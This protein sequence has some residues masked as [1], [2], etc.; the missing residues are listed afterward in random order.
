M[1]RL[2]VMMPTATYGL[3]QKVRPMDLLTSSGS[4]VT[5]AA[6]GKAVRIWAARRHL[7]GSTTVDLLCRWAP[8]DVVAKFGAPTATVTLS[9]SYKFSLRGNGAGGLES[10]R[11]GV[12]V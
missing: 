10:D 4:L 6:A 8:L 9:Y 5:A 3:S 11:G 2:Q 1:M 7:G 12:K